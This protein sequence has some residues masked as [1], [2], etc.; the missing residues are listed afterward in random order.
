MGRVLVLAVCVLLQGLPAR[1]EGLVLDGAKAVRQL[2][3]HAAVSAVTGNWPLWA[4]RLFHAA[5]G[6]EPVAKAHL[7]TGYGVDPVWMAIP[8]TTTRDTPS[9]YLFAT[10]L[11][12][13]PELDI[14]IVRPGARPEHVLHKRRATGHSP[15]LFDGQS[16]ISEQVLIRPGEDV[17]AFLRFRPQGFGILPL[18]LETPVSNFERRLAE[19]RVALGFYT[20]ALTMLLVSVVLVAALRPQGGIAVLAF[21]ASGLVLVAQIDG[22]W[23]AWLWPAAPAWNLVASFPMLLAVC[24][25][26]FRASASM[27]ATGG[28]TPASRMLRRLGWL[29]LSP[30]LLVPLVPVVWLMPIGFALL[31]LV[32]A[33]QGYGVATW[34]PLLPG[35]RSVALVAAALM[36]VGV[37]VITVHLLDGAAVLGAN[38][39]VLVKVLYALVSTPVMLAYAAHITALNRRT[40]QQ[41]ARELELTRNEVRMTADLLEAERNFAHARRLADA[42]QARLAATSHDLKQPIASLRITLGRMAP[43]VDAEQYAVLSR[44]LAFLEDLATETLADNQPADPASKDAARETVEIGVLTETVAA[45]FA[46]EAAAK[47][48]ALRH[49]RGSRLVRVPVMPVMRILTNLMSNA[50][51]HSSGGSILIG[52]RRRD[53]IDGIQICDTGPGMSEEDLAAAM[54]RHVKGASSEGSGLGLAI[55]SDLAHAHG[56]GLDICSR[57]GAGTRCLL[58]LELAASKSGIRAG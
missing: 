15:R 58:M 2:G 45:M 32:M 44:A 50:V 28:Q 47:G 23:H 40:A 20:F 3:P 22:I 1:G 27:L 10:N 29:S 46:E 7:D 48:I 9:P 38:S 35:R 6:F 13:I 25:T 56:L 5:G 26:G 30:L 52:P 21:M 51:K 33:A 14:Y 39:L 16:V 34:T 41:A 19:E 37:A 57:P 8:I 55:C 54:G 4:V 18:S 42:H 49:R 36:L 24:A 11:P 43:G 31:V 17:V 12:Y 53:G